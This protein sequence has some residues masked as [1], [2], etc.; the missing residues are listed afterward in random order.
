MVYQVNQYI[1]YGFLKVPPYDDP[2]V[3]VE[4]GFYSFVD[5][6]GAI[7]QF[8]QSAAKGTRE[9]HL[10][11]MIPGE[12]VENSTERLQYVADKVIPAFDGS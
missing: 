10:F 9:I 8:K 2:N 11:G 6:D 5:A 12:P 1:D 3:L 7:E 4:Q